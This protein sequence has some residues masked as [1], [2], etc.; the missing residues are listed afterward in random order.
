MQRRFQRL[1]REIEEALIAYIN[2]GGT[3][4]LS[5]QIRSYHLFEGSAA[6]MVTEND[7]PE[8]TRINRYS[9]EVRVPSK[10]VLYGPIE[11]IL[12]PFRLMGRDMAVEK[13]RMLIETLN[14]AT[15]R[16]GNVVDARGK[17]FT[18]DLFLEMIEKVWIE[19]DEH[20]KA[21]MPTMMA[22]SAVAAQMSSLDAD[23]ANKVKFD[24]L[25][26][27]KKEQWLAREADR[28]LVG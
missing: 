13:E 26:Q 12:E 11:E 4:M 10:A 19:F 23:P 25:M 1:E 21:I 22:G 9:S 20:G 8:Q 3:G 5:E 24:A 6:S 14:E 18:F 27:R 16:V 2:T 17:P 15:Q 7:E 28:T